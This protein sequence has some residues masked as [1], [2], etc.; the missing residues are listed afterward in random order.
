MEI[1]PFPQAA[2]SRSNRNQLRLSRPHVVHNQ[3]HLGSWKFECTKC[4][5]P[6]EFECTGMIFRSLDFYCSSCGALHVVT[7]PAFTPIVP[8]HKK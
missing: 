1:I 6:T 3:L 7:N 5:A 8:T 4:D 2:Q